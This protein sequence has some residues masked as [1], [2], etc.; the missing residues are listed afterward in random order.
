[1][2]G[3]GWGGS[4]EQW[5]QL[6]LYYA[7]KKINTTAVFFDWPEKAAKIKALQDAGCH[8]YLLPQK[9]KSLLYKWKL[10]RQLNKISFQEFDHAFINQGGWEDLLHAPFKKL[11]Q[12]LPPY[13]LCFH[14][15]QTGSRLSA[16][17][18]ILIKSWV[19][20]AMLNISDAQ[21]TFN[22]LESNFNLNI[23]RK[24]VMYNPII[25]P[26]PSSAS[27]Y[28]KN[29]IMQFVMLAALDT[30]R[31]A[32]DILI[33]TL[34][35]QKWIERNWVLHLYGDGP[36]R[37]AL[38]QLIHL[39]KLQEKIFLKGHTNKV[40]EVL[41]QTNLVL[42]CT[43]I[44]A[45]PIS[46]TEAMAM[47]RPCMVSYIGDMPLWVN[48]QNGFI[49]HDVSTFSLDETLDKAWESKHHWEGL[50]KEAFLTFKK[51]Y[52]EPYIEK[53][54]SVVEEAI[55]NSNNSETA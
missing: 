6:A 1:M 51:M 32:Q 14:N 13:I 52:P 47:A 8:V 29:E 38:E 55:P 16:K 24:K 17:K 2:N 7:K 50:G 39:K 25:F 9:N 53:L 35:S 27:P 40:Q 37:H 15:Y 19:K 18:L 54:A 21:K 48:D 12:K 44:D 45:M 22:V 43:H 23:L 28:P 10:R 5:Y 4:E 49:C 33:K 36:D 11:Y 42:Q 26:V 46:V 3:A 34:S 30:E 31:K 41:L 20:N